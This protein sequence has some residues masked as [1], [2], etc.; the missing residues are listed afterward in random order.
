M[1][2][3]QSQPPES[4]DP[5]QDRRDINQ[6]FLTVDSLAE[7]LEERVAQLEE[8]AASRWPRRWLLRWRL[9]RQLRAS[10]RNF[11]GGTWAWRRSNA[12]SADWLADQPGPGGQQ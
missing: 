8:V 1:S 9:G 5:G 6:E 3:T 2:S 4:G 12:V 7:H 10:V 11:P